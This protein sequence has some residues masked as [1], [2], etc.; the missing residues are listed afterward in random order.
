MRDA[1]RRGA[2]IRAEHIAHIRSLAERSRIANANV[3]CLDSGELGLPRAT[4]SIC[5]IELID[6]R[7]SAKLLG[8]NYFLFA[9][10]KRM[11]YSAAGG[12]AVPR[13]SYDQLGVWWPAFGPVSA[14]FKIPVTQ[15]RLTVFDMQ[16]VWCALHLGNAIFRIQLKAAFNAEGVAPAYFVGENGTPYQDVEVVVRDP[17]RMYAGLAGKRG[18][19]AYIHDGASGAFEILQLEC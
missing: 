11:A 10:G 5:L 4:P 2:I 3:L 1:I 8:S 15:R 17:F 9:V 6:E 19:A 18:Y 16:G 7:W 14:G 13:G 12:W